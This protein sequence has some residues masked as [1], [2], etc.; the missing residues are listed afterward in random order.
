MA[1]PKIVYKKYLEAAQNSELDDDEEI[2]PRKSSYRARKRMRPDNSV[3]PV[4]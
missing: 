3:Q 4:I 1:R 2:I